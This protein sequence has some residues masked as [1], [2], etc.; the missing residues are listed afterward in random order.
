MLRYDKLFEIYEQQE[1]AKNKN[2]IPPK[3]KAQELFGKIG[4]LLDLRH[5]EISEVLDFLLETKVIQEDI[6]TEDLEYWCEV[7]IEAKK[8]K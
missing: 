1:L 6:K 8:I 2:M 3:Q 5:N 4:T 7:R